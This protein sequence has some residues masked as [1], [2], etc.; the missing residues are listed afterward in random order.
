MGTKTKKIIKAI[1]I[2][3][4]W[5]IIWE[6]I[7]LIVGKE[8]LVPSPI[9]VFERLL[10]LI[11]TGNFWA[12]IGTSLLRIIIGYVAAIAAGII[13]GVIT[14][15][16]EILNSFFEPIAKI[17]RATPV[18][19]FILLLFVF[20][21]KDNIPAVTA[22]LMVLPIVWLNVYDG[23]KHSNKKLLEMAAVFKISKK[24]KA[25]KIYIPS[26]M[27]FFLTAVKTGM[28]LAW[29]SGI[30]AEAIV[31]PNFGIG[32]ML[33]DSKIYLETTDLFAWTV[34]IIILSIILEKILIK[35]VNR[36]MEK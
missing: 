20:V 1:I 26:V 28:G 36:L 10:S 13:L 4:I 14:A 19:S 21:A 29:K 18:V 3:L 11:I 25:L 35:L 23:I 9:S 27:P 16:S 7:S 22:F 33:H 6:I 12:Q 17:I 15:F 2:A 31:N 24:K 34:V 8:L 32:T 30:A 5:L